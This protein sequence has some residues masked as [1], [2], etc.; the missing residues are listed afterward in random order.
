M[1]QY[2]C[3]QVNQHI[4]LLCDLRLNCIWII[5]PLSEQYIARVTSHRPAVTCCRPHVTGYSPAVTSYRPA[6][7]KGGAC[8]HGVSSYNLVV[9]RAISS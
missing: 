4:I 7:C 8:L 1:T 6:F 9:T 3:D 2:F 5:Q